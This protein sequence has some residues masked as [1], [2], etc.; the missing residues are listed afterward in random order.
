MDFETRI[1]GVSLSGATEPAWRLRLTAAGVLIMMRLATCLGIQVGHGG[2][3]ALVA[4]H[5]RKLLALA[6]ARRDVFGDGEAHI[7]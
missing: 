6:N 2:F 5:D 1:L 3:Q 7:L 4:L